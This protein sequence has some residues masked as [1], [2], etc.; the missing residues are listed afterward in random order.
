MDASRTLQVWLPL[1]GRY[2]IRESDYFR[3]KMSGLLRSRTVAVKFRNEP[4]GNRRGPSP[5]S[6]PLT[7][8]RIVAL[9]EGLSFLVLLGIAM[10]L[11]YIAGQPEA[12]RIVGSIHGGL[13]LLY[14]IAVFRAALY[15][16]WPI[17]SIAEALVASLLPFG[18]FVFDRKV[19]HKSP[20]A[21][22]AASIDGR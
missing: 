20:P 7:Q 2:F 1:T 13:F 8:F 4:T 19:L 3:I 21:T 18:P 6:N 16:K 12:V 11:K 5:M 17:R 14:V 15:C 22:G 10:P 9:A